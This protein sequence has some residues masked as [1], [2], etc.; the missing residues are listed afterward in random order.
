MTYLLILIRISDCRSAAIRYHCS[1]SS[2]CSHHMSARCHFS[3]LS[4]PA[5]LAS[6]GCSDCAAFMPSS[7][8][9]A[10]ASPS[11]VLGVSPV[12]EEDPWLT[13]AQIS[14][15]YFVA[16]AERWRFARADAQPP[17]FLLDHCEVGRP[18]RIK[19]WIGPVDVALDRHWL[20]KMEV[21]ST[22][23]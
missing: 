1:L 21:G 11:E 2:T 14:E 6:R 20:R 13:P 4:R 10:G 8:A 22:H 3:C 23:K 7:S 12:D 17:T 19:I 9:S 5:G 18:V 15:N 16:R